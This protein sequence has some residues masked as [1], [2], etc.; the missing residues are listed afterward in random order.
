[1][2]V[3]IAGP[4]TI[5][6]LN[7]HIQQRLNNIYNKHISVVVGDANGID[8]A[9]QQYFHNLGYKNVCVYASQGKARF[10]IGN[11][12]VENV[13]VDKKAKGFD[14]YTAKDLKMA[15]VADYGFMIWNGKSKGTLNN[16]INLIIRNKKT[17]IYFTPEHQFYCID[18]LSDFEVI[19]NKCVG[20]TKI[21][22]RGLSDKKLQL[23][24]S[25]TDSTYVTDKQIMF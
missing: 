9:V 14:Y 13:K 21:L 16:I 12:K 3:F 22:Y 24:I 11:W 1:M 6:S 20:E 18:K 2:K 10:N 23:S 5:S 15:D 8:R 4:R 19:L 17:L 25:E 7:R